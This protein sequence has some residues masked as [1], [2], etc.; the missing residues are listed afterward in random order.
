MNCA[1]LKEAAAFTCV[2]VTGIH[3]EQAI[4]VSTPFT[5]A[6]GTSI[7]FYV[8]EENK[9]TLISDNGESVAHLSSMG[10]N[11]SANSIKSLAER[12]GV[13]GLSFG[14]HYDLRAIYPKSTSHNMLGQFVEG[15]LAVAQWER[16]HLR[17]TDKDRNL[18]EEAEFYLRTWKP[19]QKLEKRAKIKGQ[20]KNIYTFDFLLDNE[21]I[22]I[23]SPN[24][25]ATGAVMRKTAD[26]QNSPYLENRSIRI[27]VDDSEDS[28]RADVERAILG[29]LTTAMLFSQLQRLGQRGS[30]Q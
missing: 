2:P 15:M 30:L 21:F 10:I 24:H 3:G 7:V 13:M 5:F 25:N 18:V 4:E 27:I 14:E 12:V 17:L 1:W 11:V 22:D 9:H 28:A 29:S 8:I 20:S 6:D 23:I 16:E 19:N 26:I